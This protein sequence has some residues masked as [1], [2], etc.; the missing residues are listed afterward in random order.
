MSRNIALTLL[1]M[2]FFLSAALITGCLPAEELPSITAQETPQS[3]E[4]ASEAPQLATAKVSA[5]LSEPGR[6]QVT[7]H[8]DQ[9]YFVDAGP[10]SSGLLEIDTLLAAQVTCG[11]FVAE[12]AAQE[13]DLPLTDIAGTAAFDPATEKI[14]VY[15]DL[16]GAG[17][18]EVLDLANNLRQRC[19]IYTTLAE[20]NSVEFNPG[21]QFDGTV[22]NSAVVTA[23]LFRFGGANVTANGQTFVMDSVP[24][25]DGPNEEL[26][27]LDMMIGGLAACSTFVYEEV[28]PAANVSVLVEADFDPTGVRDL[29]GPNP[30]IQN[31]RISMQADE[32]DKSQADEVE[33][34]IKER[35][36]LHNILNG[37]VNI[38]IS[39]EQSTS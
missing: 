11:V 25:L 3:A 6:A 21:E 2:S 5:Q 14:Q 9:R 12:K 29:E 18:E 17:D 35:C 31:I 26:Y 36:Y 23:E 28:A 27:P 32:Y 24:P 20:A 22:D 16:P 8:N 34:Q 37:T 30:R 39:T 13:L 19:P 33:K 15:L 10:A 38:D 7:G 4:Q 1:V